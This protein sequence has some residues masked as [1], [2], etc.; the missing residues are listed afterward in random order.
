MKRENHCRAIL[1]STPAQR[2]IGSGAGVDIVREQGPVDQSVRHRFHVLP[3]LVRL[4]R[5]DGVDKV[6]REAASRPGDG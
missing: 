5:D 1:A 4:R 3:F 6:T 2:G